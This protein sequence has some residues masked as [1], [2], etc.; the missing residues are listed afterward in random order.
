[1]SVQLEP[2]ETLNGLFTQIRTNEASRSR[3]FKFLLTKFR[4]LGAEVLDDDVEAYMIVQIRKILSDVTDDEFHICMQVLGGTKLAASVTGQA[5]LVQIVF[6]QT[7]AALEPDTNVADL[8]QVY[9]KCTEHAMP[10]FSVS[11]S[12]EALFY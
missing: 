2:K 4:C 11:F 6:E 12:I 1:M 7:N 10:Y 9:I 3:C 8:V 5:E